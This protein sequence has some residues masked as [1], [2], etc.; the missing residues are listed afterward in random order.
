MQKLFHFLIFISIY[1]RRVRLVHS[2]AP[3]PPLSVTLYREKNWYDV[4]SF[5][6]EGQ[7][8]AAVE[9]CHK[10]PTCVAMYL[11]KLKKMEAQ[12]GETSD[13]ALPYVKNSDPAYYTR[14]LQTISKAWILPYQ[15]TLFD[16]AELGSVV[17]GTNTSYNEDYGDACYA[18]VMGTFSK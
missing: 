4:L 1:G 11:S 17:L 12:V 7:L 15:P 14:F 13:K 2:E 18:R 3:P 6:V 9:A 10:K 16:D 5:F 8:V